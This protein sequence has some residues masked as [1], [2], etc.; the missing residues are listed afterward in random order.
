MLQEPSFTGVQWETGWQAIPEPFPFWKLKRRK[1]K[2][3]L[4]M[5]MVTH[6]QGLFHKSII[7]TR[8]AWRP[9]N[10]CAWEWSH[11]TKVFLINPSS[12]R[13]QREGLKSTAE[14]NLFQHSWS[15]H[16]KTCHMDP[17]CWQ[18]R[19]DSKTT[20]LKSW[21][22]G[23]LYKAVFQPQQFQIWPLLSRNLHSEAI[24]AWKDGYGIFWD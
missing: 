13:G 11:T 14:N 6:N 19:E 22:K 7:N 17:L 2:K 10:N 18:V 20:Y 3:E 16:L 5:R 9:E 15:L 24:M 21:H 4:C 8:A 12:T 23:P 1:K